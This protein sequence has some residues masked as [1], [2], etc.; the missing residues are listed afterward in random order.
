MFK[1]VF[2]KFT[3]VF[4]II[5]V[6]SLVLL[7]FII[8]SVARSYALDMKQ[9]TLTDITHSISYTIGRDIAISDPE[10]FD[11]YVG[12]NK[13]ELATIMSVPIYNSETYAVITDL[14]GVILCA[15]ISSKTDHS[16]KSIPSSYMDDLLTNGRVSGDGDPGGFFGRNSSFVGVPIKGESGNTLGAIYVYTDN[17][18]EA[19]MLASLIKT[20][21]LATMWM[22]IAVLLGVFFITE[23]MTGPLKKMS[24]AAKDFA[25]GR[26]DTRVTV[27]GN[28]E[29][30]ELANAF[31]NMAVSLS[32]F[33]N[34]RRTFLG[35]VSHDLRT[36]MTTISGYIDGILDGTIPPEERD[37]YLQI[38]SDEVKRLS[39]LVSALLD[40][41][42]MQ[43][44]ETKFS[45]TVFDVAE[46]ARRI[47][48]SF[49]KQIDEKR[50]DVEFICDKHSMLAFADKDATHR[51]LY[52]ICD[53][54]VKFSRPGGKY[55]INIHAKDKTIYVSV[56]NEGVG[57]AEKD[58]PF[59]FDRFYKADKSRG[60]D[61]KGVGLGMYISRTI[62]EAQG[63]KI[64]VASEYDKYCEFTITLRESKENRIQS[65]N[66]EN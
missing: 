13:E 26:F 18:S 43:A 41:S 25:Q 21:I 64:S 48:I 27:I 46:M 44:G 58:L 42:K 47:L 5:T 66:T 63:E 55:R 53:N 60:L 34:M 12:E 61:K 1:S 31:N 8:T 29:I 62:M 59:I 28:D 4:M 35:N 11:E 54:A 30:A 52:N 49:E 15:D 65:K 32:E 10:N 50:L 36:P 45:P 9:E 20:V 39:R 3:T 22:L 6:T 2:S 14:N 40:I 24:R 33:E 7:A 51:V 16:E 37:Q 19:E 57:I 56:Y 23:R 38:V 17:R